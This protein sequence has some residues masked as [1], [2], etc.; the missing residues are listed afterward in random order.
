VSSGELPSPRARNLGAAGAERRALEA[1]CHTERPRKAPRRRLRIILPLGRR[2]LWRRLPHLQARR[3]NSRPRP[4]HRRSRPRASPMSA[5]LQLG[6]RRRPEHRA[7]SM[8]SC[9]CGC[10]F[11]RQ[12]P[13]T[14][15]LKS[16]SRRPESAIRSTAATRQVALTCTTPAAGWFTRCER[17]RSECEQPQASPTS[18]RSSGFATPEWGQGVRR[19]SPAG[20]VRLT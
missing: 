4:R 15:T 3:D 13:A 9:R 12:S 1:L 14:A 18:C 19:S 16:G 17:E 20:S 5:V 11:S 10:R 6:Q 7:T 2:D 8:E